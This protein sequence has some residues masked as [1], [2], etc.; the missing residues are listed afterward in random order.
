[1]LEVIT[2][3]GVVAVIIAAGYHLALKEALGPG[4][5]MVLANVVYLVATPALLFDILIDTDPREIFSTG[6][7]VIST[8]AL[9]AGFLGFLLL[10]LRGRSKPDSLIG[11][12]ASSYANAGN[13]GIPLA[14]YILDDAAAVVPVIL[15]QVAFYA[16]STLT[17]LDLMNSSKQA[18]LMRNLLQA[19]TNPMLMAAIAGMTVGY[20]RIPVPVILSEPVGLLA[21]AAVPLALLVFGMSLL[22]SSVR[23]NWD[24]AIVVILKNFVHPLVAGLIAHLVFGMDG[25]ALLAAV[26]LAALPTAQNVLTYALRFRTNEILA[27]D[28]GVVSTLVSFPVLILITY[29]LG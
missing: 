11:M 2:G 8:S 14:V 1:M 16:P 24:V 10:R 5:R 12:L 6:F 19:L 13:L 3:F 27:R 26:V 20:V 29:L 4:A 18:S 15:F 21:G 23:P 7:V 22:G 28:A 17:V 9:I 25:A